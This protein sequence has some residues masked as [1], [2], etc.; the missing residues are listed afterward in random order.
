MRQFELLDQAR[1][2]HRLTLIVEDHGAGSPADRRALT[3]LWPDVRIEPSPDSPVGSP[4]VAGREPE[5]ARWRKRVRQ[6]RAD[7]D[8]DRSSVRPYRNPAT[9]EAVS[10]VVAEHVDLFEVEYVQMFRYLP[11]ARQAPVVLV[12]LD[13]LGQR[14]PRAAGVEGA[15]Q[16]V[17][18]G[19][20]RALRH[21]AN[22]IRSADA[23]IVTGDHERRAAEAAGARRVFVVPNGA[24]DALLDV[25]VG[26]PSERLLFVGWA[27]HTPNRDALGWWV[28][29]VAP[30]LPEGTALDVVGAGWEGFTDDPRIRL[31]GFVD[32]MGGVLAGALVVVPL[33]VGGGTKLK[34][35][36]AMAAGRPI[37]LTSIAAEGLPIRDG[38]EAIVRDTPEGI[39]AAIAEVRAEPE[40]RARLGQAAREAARPLLWSAIR[41]QMEP[42]YEDL[43]RARTAGTPLA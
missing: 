7:L 29:K 4:Q 36:E 6:L 22:A 35:A 3:T 28:D 26:G 27:G 43:V 25:A 16:H 15:A 39:A 23:V 30:R 14:D 10:R 1:A 37:V 32:D 40:L 2:E 41:P 24:D 17:D 42:V 9:V 11:P 18:L 34:V 13:V 31:L 33:R 20:R 5:M 12:A 38:R 8:P 21:E 19:D